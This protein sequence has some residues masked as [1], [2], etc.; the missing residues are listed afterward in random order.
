MD[1]GATAWHSEHA[2]PV[3]DVKEHIPVADMEFPNQEIVH[4]I[5]STNQTLR[6]GLVIKTRHMQ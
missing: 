2:G 4:K 1:H 6:N 5:E 3:F